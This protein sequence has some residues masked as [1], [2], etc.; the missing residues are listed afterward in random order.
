MSIGVTCVLLC[1]VDG[2]MVVLRHRRLPWDQ[3]K[4]SIAA[5]FGNELSVPITLRAL[6]DWKM[7]GRIT[8]AHHLT[9]VSFSALESINWAN[10]VHRSKWGMPSCS[11]V[12]M[13]P[14][15]SCVRFCICRLVITNAAS[16]VDSNATRGFITVEVHN[17]TGSCKPAAQCLPTWLSK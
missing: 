9:E 2:G 14:Q 16:M 1:Q 12:P 7:Y 8:V 15:M 13:N 3:L 10:V 6:S 5:H 11:P 4:S 17:K